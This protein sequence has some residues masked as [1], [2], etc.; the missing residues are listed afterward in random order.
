M[1]ISKIELT[2]FKSY[3]HAEFN[4]PEPTDDRNIVLIGGMNGYGKT[5]ILE[6]LYLC[7]YGKDSMAHLARAGLK[8]DDYRGYPTFLERALNGEAKRDG[9]DQM[10]VRVVINRTKTKGIDIRRRWYFK[11]STGA[12]I[13]EEE[14]VVREVNRGV[15]GLPKTDG[16]A[17][18]NL[19]DL[20]D[21]QFVPAH[22]APFFFF[23]GEEVKKLAD[24][25]RIEQVKQGLEG[26][27]GVVLLR[28]LADRLKRFESDKRSTIANVDEENIDRLLEALTAEEKRLSDL[29]TDASVSTQQLS[30]LKVERDS[31]IERITAAG[32]GG[33]DIATVKDLVEEREQVRS[34]QRDVR[35]SLEKILADKLPFHL[36]P[37]G[38]LGEFRNQL[39]ME[40]AL[41]DWQTECRALQPKRNQFE[42]A[43]LGATSPEL[44]PALTSTQIDAIK[45]RIETAWA[46]LFHPP[47]ANCA[48]TVT[49]GYLHEG[50]RERAL[51]FLNSISVGQQDVQDLLSEQR[52]HG[53]RIEELSRK[54]AR[55]EGID[56]DGTIADLKSHLARVSQEIENMETHIR[57]D[58]RQIIGLETTVNNTRARYLQE[59]KRR[60]ETSPVRGLLN[61][62]ERVRDV[63]D[64][65]I[66]ALFPLKVQ[67][68]ANAMT[69]VYKQLAH[70]DQVSKIVIDNDGT[71]TI[72]G[73]TGKEIRFDRSAGENQIFATAL[74][75]GLAEVSGVR[76]PMVVDTPLG[77]LD[78]LHRENIFRFWTGNPNRQV[79][80]LSQDEEIDLAF[81]KR[82]SKHVSTTYLLE[83]E[84]V[85]DS[86]GR[87]TVKEGKYFGVAK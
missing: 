68:L 49:H 38:I 80:L 23:D 76:A 7:L 82:I 8:A 48:E 9:A 61:K 27:L 77:R 4:F 5:T 36:M 62:S 35:K 71:T 75:A 84:D 39:K 74:I 44:S 22:I 55:V 37:S 20:L 72:L 3:Q 26:L 41:A 45:K 6:A 15:P 78:S 28:G 81:Y 58:E 73:K 17:N 59:R 52:E 66:P 47:P 33:G 85:G 56:R 69:K 67:A 31:Y 60:D 32:G 24:Q 86:L 13:H 11:S 10:S 30:D 21:D 70:K 65:L 1:W 63:I 29:Q 34:L 16:K 42:S 53:E 43:F 46:S 19:S 54:I 25:S 57:N 14:A 50:L 79:I 2:H 18:F 12:W 40:V 64:E 51:A 87:T 83:H